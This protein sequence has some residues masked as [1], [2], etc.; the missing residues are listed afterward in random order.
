MTLLDDRVE[1]FTT[2]LR[3]S[4]GRWW[5]LCA[6]IVVALRAPF[7]GVPLGI[8]EG[9][10]SFVARAWGTTE[11]SMYGNS[12]LDRPPLLVMVYKLGV[13]G[14][15]LGVRLLGMAAALLLVAGTMAIAHRISGP[16]AAR[17]AGVITA[18]MTSSVVLGAV[19]TDNELLA[20]VPATLSILMLV[21]ARDAVDPRAWLFASG[22]LA[23]CALLIKQSFGEALVAGVVFL[24][25]SWV[26]RVGS[27]FRSRWVTWW[28][29]GTAAP[30]AITFAWFEAYSVGAQR[31]VYAI[32]G[33]RV[34]SLNQ[35]HASPHGAGY[36]LVHLGLPIA[37]ASGCLFLVPW[38][39]SWLLRHRADP[40]LV[41]PL[42]AWL[43]VG[44]VGVA[45]GGNY[46][47][48][49]FIQPLAALAVLTGCA[50]AVTTRR[51]LFAATAALLAVLAVGNVAVG[52]TMKSVNPPQ[53]RTLAVADYLRSNAETDD[54][55]YVLYARA[56]LL[57]YARMRTP[58]PYSWSQM[59][60]TVPDAEARLRTMLRSSTERPT[61]IVE[62]QPAT[63]FGMDGSG[64]TRR[65]IARHYVQTGEIC[66]KPIL[67]RKDQADRDLVPAPD[68]E[69][70]TLNLPRKL[71]PNNSRSP[72]D[73]AD[74]LWQ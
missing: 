30:V 37:I 23:T 47:P 7:L 11:G 25:V 39:V 8:D 56:N 38:S 69:C 62:W 22:F 34:D 48:H 55:L 53:Q 16:H 6:T 64:E 29:I 17:I 41:L 52:A 59:V 66:D 44:F 65:L 73:S 42:A 24:A 40:R 32:A 12:W 70:A 50:L 36:M 51:R 43:A 72:E 13:L 49:Y 2:R 45:G 9:G 26:T 18:V 74:Y 1:V 10:D 5:L 27:G 60:R 46:Y 15:D 58:Y 21:R 68:V 3:G 20:T 31:F 14:G 67:I 33:F 61:W 57:Y 4:M 35:L 71:G 54:S 19:F 63:L 28:V